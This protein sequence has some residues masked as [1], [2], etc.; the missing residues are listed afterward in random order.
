MPLGERRDLMKKWDAMTEGERTKLA[1]TGFPGRPPEKT[2][3]S[4]VPVDV[5]VKLDQM[6]KEWPYNMK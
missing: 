1:L 6:A 2:K 3:A 4:E 5:Q